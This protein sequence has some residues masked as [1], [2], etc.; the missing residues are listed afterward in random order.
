MNPNDYYEFQR[1]MMEMIAERDNSGERYVIMTGRQSG[2]TYMHEMY[3]KWL[4]VYEK[5]QIEPED[6]FKDEEDL[7]KL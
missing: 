6:Y 5:T 2:K 4:K 3:Q 7:F 1:R